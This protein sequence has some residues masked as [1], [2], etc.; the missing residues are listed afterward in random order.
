MTYEEL[1]NKIRQ[2]RNESFENSSQL[3][4]GQFISEIERIGIVAEHNNEIKDV[5][6]DFGSAIPTTLD[7]WRGAYEELALGYELSGYD[8]NSK[9]FSDCKADKF[10]E[11]LKSAIGKEYTGWK[12]GEFIMNEDTPVWVS[13]S[14]NSDDT[15]IIGILDDGWR[16]I[17]LTAFCKY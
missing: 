1:N 9:H 6:F 7:S 15:G 10:L 14:G 11:Q 12:G 2:M 4:L 16:I 17:V 3:T 5:C 8:N 13:N